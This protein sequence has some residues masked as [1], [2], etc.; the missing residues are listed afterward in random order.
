MA[1]RQR[2]DSPHM[3]RGHLLGVLLFP[4][5]ADEMKRVGAISQVHDGHHEQT[6][7]PAE[8]VIA[9]R[10][11]SP[12]APPRKGNTETTRKYPSRQ[13]GA[14]SASSASEIT[15]DTENVVI[16]K[17]IVAATISISGTSR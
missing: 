11:R 15:T 8:I 1:K 13:T 17:N 12:P 3:E 2:F 7:L 5:D 14:A 6:S 10:S 16:A 9:D 4:F